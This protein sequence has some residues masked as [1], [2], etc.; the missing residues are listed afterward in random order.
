MP[1]HSSSLL[2]STSEQSGAQKPL[3]LLFAHNRYRNRGGEDESRDQEIALLRSKGHEVFEY[4]V[5]NKDISRSSYLMAGL[6]SIWNTEQQARLTKFMQ[7]TKPHILKVD[8]YFPILSPSVFSAAKRLGIATV[9]SV[10][11]YRMICPGA[12]LFRDGQVCTDCVG[13]KLAVSAIRHKC[14]RGSHLQSAAVAVSNGFAHLFGTWEHSIDR[15]IAVSEFVKKELIRGGFPRDKISVKANSIVDT[16]VGSGDGGY[17]LFV[18]RLIPEKGIQTLL[19]AWQKLGTT[20]P[21]KIIGEGSLEDLVVAAS[22]ANSNIEYMKRQPISAVCEY[23]GRASFLV[24]PSEWYEPFGRSIVEAYSKGTPVIG[25]DTEPM[26]DMIESGKTGL[27]FRA[28]DSDDL[29]R[30]IQSMAAD[31]ERLSHMRAQARLRY[32]EGYSSE[33]NYAQI[34]TIFGHA[35]STQ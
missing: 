16:G 29:A 33:D 17:A 20:L 25:A 9:L 5:D 15:Y 34:M 26:R 8:N 30:A 18:G 19:D 32:L 12:S 21:L 14:Y 31:T 4:E 27:F 11:N 28:G 7:Q 22:K 3:R 1:S 13:S 23:M 35:L 2:D 10:R 6:Q 24:F